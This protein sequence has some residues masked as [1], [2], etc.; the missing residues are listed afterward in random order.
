MT[1]VE[2]ADSVVIYLC[3]KHSVLDQI[4][5]IIYLQLL[6]LCLST[7]SETELPTR[8]MALVSCTSNTVS[9]SFRRL[10]SS[11]KCFYQ[12]SVSLIVVYERYDAK[13]YF[14]TEEIE[15][16]NPCCKVFHTCISLQLTYCHVYTGFELVIGFIDQLQI[17]N[18]SNCTAIINSH[19]RQ[20]ITARTKS[21]KSAVFTSRCLV[22]AFPF[23]S[24]PER[25]SFLG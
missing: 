24:V 21:S 11:F 8:Y 10:P 1:E 22:T 23:L 12:C 2:M 16:Y 25:S 15:H 7:G 14:I 3:F 4:A 17:G 6:R 9:L 20:F 18:T 13:T 5:C 19:T